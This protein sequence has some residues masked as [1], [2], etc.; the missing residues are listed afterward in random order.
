MTPNTFTNRPLEL[1]DMARF[2]V[3]A[4]TAISP[5]GMLVV[6]TRTE[7][8]NG[9]AHSSLWVVSEGSEARPLTSGPADS[10]PQFIPDGSAVL[11]LRASD[12]PAQV[13]LLPI[14]GGEARA[15]SRAAD[16]PRGVAAARVSPDGLRLAITAPVSRSATVSAVE[17]PIVIDR[18]GYKTDG[19]GWNAAVRQH[20]FVSEIAS[21][22]V[23]R[24]SDG[25]WNASEASWSPDGLLIAFTAAIEPDSDL[26]WTSGAYVLDVD[27][28][29]PS[30]RRVGQAMSVTGALTW[31]PDGGS[32][33]AVGNHAPR[34]GHAELLRLYVGTDTA[35]TSL[36]APLDRNVMAGFPAYPGGRPAFRADGSEV[37]YCARDRGWTRLHAVAPDGTGS[38]A[39][40]AGPHQ[41]VSA[42]SVASASERVAFV[43]TTQQSLGEVVT[44][45]LSTGV[46]TVLTGLREST[47]ADI[48]LFEAEEREFTI[49][50]GTRIHGWLLSA[51]DTDGAAPL[52]LDI[53]GGPHNA[54][55]G[56]ADGVH[57][58]HQVLAA[59][60]WRILMVNPRGSDGYG[61]AFY[62]AVNGAWG[63]ADERDFLEP[64][65]TLVAEGLADPDRLAVTGYSYGGFG[66]CALTAATTRFAAAVAGG[67]ICNFSSMAADGEHAAFF[68]EMSTGVA[69]LGHYGALLD[70]SPIARVTNVKTPTL[71]L[72]GAQDASCPVGQ[73]EEWFKAL[74]LSHVPTRLVVYPGG[75]HL[76]ILDGPIEHR[77]DYNR[78]LIEWLESYARPV[79]P[80]R[81]RGLT[82]TG[83]GAGFWRRRLDVLRTRYGV[84]AAQFGIVR[85]N[86]NG[87]PIERT[88]ASS[89]VLDTSSGVSTTDEALFQIGSITKVWTTV[90][91]MQLV[92]EGRL[93][94][95][96]PVQSILPDFALADYATAAA[97]TV[98]HLL[99]HTSGI[100]G[101]LFT[102]T[103][104]GD[105]CIERYVESLKS[106]KQVHPIDERF[107]YCNAGFVVAGRIIEVLRDSTWDA[108][109]QKHIIGPMGLEHTI[110]LASDAPR[111]ATATGH[112]GF[113]DA[114]VPV[115]KWSITRSMGPAGLITA[116]I[117]D[118]LSFAQTALRGGVA[119]N[120]NRILSAE[121]A[122]A[123]VEEQVSLRA[124]SPSTTGWGL[125]W[126]LEDWQ[127]TFVYGHDGGTIGQRAYLRVFPEDGFALAL[128]T[129]GGQS[130][131]LYR[132]LFG[133]AASAM[134]AARIPAALQANSN[135][136]S[137]ALAGEIALT[138]RNYASGGAALT[139]ES[140]ENNPRLTMRE[141]TDIMQNGAE[142]EA[143]TL[144]LVPATEPGVL[145]FTTPDTA[146]WAQFRPLEKGAYLG[147]RYMPHGDAS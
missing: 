68:S 145:L 103:G 105:D 27:A 45:D 129:T 1:E 60:G 109:L 97:V 92:D 114:A 88:T 128:L 89:G 41:V 96:A 101:D 64:I 24:L 93:D 2:V 49:S 70:G 58:Y 23:R 59:K 98:R 81:P 53:H 107:S 90:L 87:A 111:F 108:A 104:P 116:S 44:F 14:G 102:D 18:L 139:F 75:S 142:P 4:E 39:L 61:D 37:L 94:L 132:E 91:I 69:P 127:G 140:A 126:F 144:K 11:F 146:G 52:L 85:L 118:L 66:T 7:T 32:V 35:D 5:D 47:L 95:D 138:P 33:I 13:Y 67:L 72:H 113:G 16:F 31:S 43:L 84:T 106:A 21:G 136:A 36:T 78:R 51:P 122:K 28:K 29:M 48:E 83:R 121:S 80:A 57:L 46:L 141:L 19:L 100:D 79:S 134:S 63:T 6:F 25:D 133:D 71:I 10:A 50:D 74:R 62:R 124:V 40:V 76:F 82:A 34:T 65:D 99:I 54:W 110:T 26:D 22:R 42:L 131:G 3:P 12:G 30:P 73:A 115:P 8:L 117:G 55:S 123:M 17:E 143:T 15:L 119:P 130:D 147:Y 38:R 135:E 86:E 20:I 56:V 125:G 77:I 9:N 137:T 112:S 120:G